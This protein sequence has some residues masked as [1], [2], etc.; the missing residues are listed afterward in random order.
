[1]ETIS[2]V[3]LWGDLA[4]QEGPLSLLVAEQTLVL[5]NNV[6]QWPKADGQDVL[7]KVFLYAMCCNELE[8]TIGHT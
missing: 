1:M 4:E 5:S 7:E 3:F 6:F 8:V 2:N